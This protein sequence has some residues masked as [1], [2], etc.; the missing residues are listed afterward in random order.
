MRGD[1]KFAEVSGCGGTLPSVT[2]ASLPA[3]EDAGWLA[4]HAHLFKWNDMRGEYVFE[5]GNPVESI[6]DDSGSPRLALDQGG[7]P[8]RLETLIGQ[9]RVVRSIGIAIEASRL[10]G[11]QLDHVLLLGEAGLGKRLLRRRSGTS[12]ERGWRRRA[13]R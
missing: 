1:A 9:E 8:I 3:S 7:Q 11:R 10:R 13:A 12:S 4:R 5:A 6:V 2:F